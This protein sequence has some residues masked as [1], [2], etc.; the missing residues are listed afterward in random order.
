MQKDMVKHERQLEAKTQVM[1]AEIHKK[2]I[3]SFIIWVDSS[4]ER[5][6]IPISKF[7]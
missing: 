1:N 2:S 6:N 5:S 7:P 3:S 4:E